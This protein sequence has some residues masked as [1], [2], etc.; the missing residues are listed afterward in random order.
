MSFRF[1]RI[2]LFFD[3]PTVTSNDLK[4]YRKFRKYLISNGFVMMQ[5]SIYV[6]LLLNLSMAKY[7]CDNLVK[8]K[9]TNGLVQV[10]IITEAQYNRIIFLVGESK[11][12]VLDTTDRLV[13]L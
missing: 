2:L 9:P 7:I 6:R 4:Q 10:L 12:E 13:I 5:E 3:L 1:V 11:S 8:N